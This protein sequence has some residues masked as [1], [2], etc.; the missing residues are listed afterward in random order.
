MK[1]TYQPSNVK[2]ARTHGFRARMQT[3][4]RHEC[5]EAKK[6]QGTEAIDRLKE[7]P[8]SRWLCPNVLWV[9][10]PFQRSKNY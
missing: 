5:A 8:E 4:G 10:S 9:L 7:Y 2:R 6:G 1:R 3:S